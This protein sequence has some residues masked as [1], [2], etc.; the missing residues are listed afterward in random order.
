VPVRLPKLLLVGIIASAFAATVARADGVD[1]TVTIGRGGGSIDTTQG[2]SQSDPIIV[3]D[4]S[5]ITDFQY[6]GEM[7]LSALYVEVI[8]SSGEG[9]SALFLSEFFDCAPGI[10]D[11]CY[12]VS[13]TQLPAVEFAFVGPQGFITPGTHF[14]VAVPEPSTLVLLLIGIACA[15]GFALKRNTLLT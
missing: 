10:A 12:T 15:I 9:G 6:V 8:P 5:G 2:S 1:P 14:Y 13:P 3:M 7:A 11:K 4:G